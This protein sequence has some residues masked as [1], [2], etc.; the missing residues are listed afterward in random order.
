MNKKKFRQ[1]F[2]VGGA[3]FIG[4][5]FCLTSFFKLK[6]TGTFSVVDNTKG[7]TYKNMV[8]PSGGLHLILSF[9]FVYY[10]IL[11]IQLLGIKLRFG[12]DS[13]ISMTHT[14]VEVENPILP[15]F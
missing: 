2:V 12:T 3:G 6:K 10:S 14:V 7:I 9:K 8:M 5:H 1:A 4:S 15:K 11:L 13:L